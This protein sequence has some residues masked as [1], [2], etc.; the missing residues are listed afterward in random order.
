MKSF[1]VIIFLFVSFGAFCNGDNKKPNIL[2][3]TIDDLRPVLGTYNHPEVKSPGIDK[4]A[5]HGIQFD[6]SYCN[7]PV[8][9]A[10]RASLLSGMRPKWPNRFINWKSWAD[11]DAPDAISLPEYFKNNGYTTISNGKIFHHQYDKNTSWSEESWRPDTSTVIHYADL[12]YTD[13]LSIQFINPKTG[14]GPY[15]EC[16]T[17]FDS[18]YFDNKVLNKSINDLKRLAKADKPFFL[19]VGF[20]KPHLPF[21]APKRF[22]DLYDSVQIADNRYFPENMPPLVKNSGEIFIYGRLEHY[23]STEFHYEARKAYYA[24]VSYVDDLVDKLLNT[25]NELGL[26]E[27]TIVVLIGDHG[28]HLG[29]HNFWGKHNVLHNALQTPMIIKVPGVTPRKVNQIVEFV[30]IYPTL[31]ELAGLPKLQHLQGESMVSLMKGNNH[32]WKDRAVCEWEGARTVIT[33]NFS[34]TNWIANNNSSEMLFDYT[35]DPAE[36]KNVVNKP[37]YF[38]VVDYHKKLLESVY[39]TLK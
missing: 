2:F 10:S 31:V 8:C 30:D 25:L 4:L 20:H 26:E 5:T 32:D 13:S 7:V 39:S 35:K 23:N 38:N 3:I 37:E 28:F 17:G 9:G 16:S 18:L 21:N 6:R 27:N 34:Y 14:A 12:D 19:G 11:E 29:E 33:Q 15:F 1:I 22:Y 36:N 24:C